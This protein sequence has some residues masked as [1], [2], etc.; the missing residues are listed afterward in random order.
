MIRYLADRLGLINTNILYLIISSLSCF[1]IW[2]FAYTYGTL[3]A[4]MAIFGFFCGSYFTLGKESTVSKKFHTTKA[5]LK[6]V[7]PITASIL[8]MEKFATGLSMVLISNVAAVF[9]PNIASAVEGA[10]GGVSAEPFFSYK[11]FAGV[12][13]ILAAAIMIWVKF[14]MNRNVFAKV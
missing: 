5:T 14:S 4:Y 7:S 3:V 10:V 2:V 13:Y 8:G 12:A 6:I 1:L 9:G 11:M